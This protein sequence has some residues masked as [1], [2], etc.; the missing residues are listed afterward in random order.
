MSILLST[1]EE[2]FCCGTDDLSHYYQRLRK[3]Q[4][5]C[6]LFCISGEADVTLDLKRYHLSADCTLLL[7]PESIFSV[8]RRSEGFRV[9]YFS[10]SKEMFD[11]ACFR[12][13]PT[14]IH[15]L[16]ENPY[17]H[18]KNA[19]LLKAIHG[20]VEASNAIYRDRENRFRN[21]IAQNHLQVFF[22]D[23]YDKTQRIFS[24]QQNDESNRKEELFKR[25]ISLV[26]THCKEHHDVAFY[27][28]CL[29]ISTRYLSA[30]T[31][32]IGQKSAKEII[33]DY[34]VLELKMT[35]QTTNLTLKEI[36]DR[37]HFPDQSFFGRYF[38]RHTGMS[39][40]EFRTE[41]R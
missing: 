2:A 21:A 7:L 11:A 25:F 20:L 9:H 30:I 38:K 19:E 28:D 26:H 6:L 22:L 16:K 8:E 40:K 12:L 35:L 5:G 27:A 10:Y 34:L 32:V 17:Y 4:N 33:D 1:N 3:Q 14:F 15:F 39:P 29:C 24:Q 37:F 31:R 41:N 23:T 13:E 18:H 36:A